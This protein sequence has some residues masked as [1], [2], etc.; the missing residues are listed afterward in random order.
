MRE[1]VEPHAALADAQEMLGDDQMAGTG[2]GEKFRN[3]LQ[4]AK[5]GYFNH[6]SGGW[7]AILDS[8]Q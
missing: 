7:W 5:Y 6:E 4:D 3:S 1:D 8:D 2:D